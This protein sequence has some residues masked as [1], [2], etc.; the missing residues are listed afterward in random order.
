MPG[1]GADAAGKGYERLL[2]R[3]SVQIHAVGNIAEPLQVGQAEAPR[4]RQHQQGVGAVDREQVVGVVRGDRGDEDRPTGQQRPGRQALG[5]TPDE[6]HQGPGEKGRSHQQEVVE[7]PGRAVG[8][9]WTDHRQCQ[10][11]KRRQH[12][13]AQQAKRQQ[14]PDHDIADQLLRD[15]P[16][17]AVKG[18]SQRPIVRIER[19]AVQVIRRA[20]MQDGLD[21]ILQRDEVRE[22]ADRIHAGEAD[23]ENDA[24]R[25]SAHR[26]P[27]IDAQHPGH[28]IGPQRPAVEG[29]P[30][31]QEPAD[32]EED[33]D[34]VDA[35]DG[36]GQP[37]ERLVGLG[38]LRQQEG[39]GEKHRGRCNDPQPVEIRIVE[40]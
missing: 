12:R 14:Q 22:E 27:G 39:V 9:P 21:R 24:G 11:Q 17:R 28:D 8:P 5:F 34:P 2:D 35:C 30:G 36:S 4:G 29:A 1:N 16:K 37:I 26:Q 32:D 33:A 6:E 23:P 38:S 40:F 3:P 31:D 18:P 13:P 19:H 25:Q 7:R 20:G 15:R 10:K